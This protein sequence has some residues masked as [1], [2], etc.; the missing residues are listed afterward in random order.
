MA[1]TFRKL[2]AT[3]LASLLFASLSGC[4]PSFDDDLSTVQAPRVLAI[5]ASPAEAAPGASVTLSTLVARPD[6]APSPLGWELC[7]ARKPLTELGPVSPECLL[8][9][10]ADPDAGAPLGDGD[11]LTVKLPSDA[12]QVFGPIRPQ[13]VAGQAQGRPVDPDTTGGYYQPVTANLLGSDQVTLGA[14]R[15]SCPLTS[16]TPTELVAFGALYRKNQ[17][18][19]FST[20]ARVN[21][22]GDS[23]PIADGDSVTVAHGEIVQLRAAWPDCPALPVCG[24]GI[25]GQSED[26]SNCAADCMTPVGCTGAETFP[27]FD[28]TTQSIAQHRESIRISWYASGGRLKDPVTGR[29]EGEAMSNSENSW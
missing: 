26:P 2:R 23:A 1:L 27:V 22:A 15:L 14:V 29:G 10:G 6:G 13:A 16:A 7:L 8:P 18:P 9:P 4:I 3:H 5:Q 25:C 21:A 11:S 28:S 12:C 17:N 20:L 24:D 19:E